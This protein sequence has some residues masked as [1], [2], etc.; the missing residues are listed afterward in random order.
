MLRI[1]NHSL[2]VNSY[3]IHEH[4]FDIL[5]LVCLAEDDAGLGN[6]GALLVDIE[7][8]HHPVLARG[9]GNR[10]IGRKMP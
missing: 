5:R 8:N 4:Y 9:I 2:A 1:D 6:A 3:H 10:T 7:H